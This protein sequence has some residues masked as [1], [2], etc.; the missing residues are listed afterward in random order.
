MDTCKYVHYEIDA[1]MDSE[2]PGSKDHTPSQE[3]ALTQSVGGDSNADRLFPPQVL[4]CSENW[5][6]LTDLHLSRAAVLV[7]KQGI[8]SNLSCWLGM[9]WDTYAY[10][11]EGKSNGKEGLGPWIWEWRK[12]RWPNTTSCS[13]SVVISATWTSVSW[14]SL[15][16]WWLTHLGIFTWSCPM[17]PWQMMRCAGSTYQYCRMMAF[18][19]SGSQAGNAVQ[20]YVGMGRYS[21]EW[22]LGGNKILGFPSLAIKYMTESALFFPTET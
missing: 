18:S 21:T 13:G 9:E 17:G 8:V 15:Q 12:G 7:G 22:V 19:S 3:L 16:L 4:V 1:C 20:R 5:S 6:Q 2:A 10:K 11:G 14:E